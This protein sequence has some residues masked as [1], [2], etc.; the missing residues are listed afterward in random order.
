M[1]TEPKYA[2]SL[3]Q[4]WATL[5]ILGA[6]KFETR[7]WQINSKWLP[8]ELY[9]HASFR[10][11]VNFHS[12]LKKEPFKK[13]DQFF[14]KDEG[15][16]CPTGAIIGRV[17]VKRIMTTSDWEFEHSFHSTGERKLNRKWEMEK[18]FGD[19]GPNRYAWQLDD[20]IRLPEPV[21]CGG[22]LSRWRIPDDV[23]QL[24]E[25]QEEKLFSEIENSRTIE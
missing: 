5:V 20:V 24:V 19:Y 4:P 21:R 12:L 7:G 17:T 2:I 22:A 10:P 6:K 14:L 1:N 3:L 13:F 11:P 8:S 18:A 25:L 16:V 9:I 23:L 15:I